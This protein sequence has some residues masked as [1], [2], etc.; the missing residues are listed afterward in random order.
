LLIVSCK[1][2]VVRGFAFISLNKAWF[3]STLRN[4]SNISLVSFGCLL[5]WRAAG[6]GTL[7]EKELTEFKLVPWIGSLE[8][9]GSIEDRRATASGRRSPMTWCSIDRRASELFRRAPASSSGFLS[10]R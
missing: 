9:L 10:S 4:V 5:R 3:S 7:E 8:I 1:N 2:I 6:N